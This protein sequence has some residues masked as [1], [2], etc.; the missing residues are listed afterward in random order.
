MCHSVIRLRQP[1]FFFVLPTVW[2]QCKE[3]HGIRLRML[4]EG[5]KWFL[6]ATASS[7]KLGAKD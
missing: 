1:H 7:A 3:T 4:I 2:S 5:R 6:T